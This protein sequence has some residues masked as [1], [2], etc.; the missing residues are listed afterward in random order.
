MDVRVRVQLALVN[1]DGLISV[2]VGEASQTHASFVYP[3]YGISLK[4]RV[5]L[6]VKDE[7]ICETTR[8]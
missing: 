2:G 4:V 7:F 1:G 3:K 5:K 6:F 8:D